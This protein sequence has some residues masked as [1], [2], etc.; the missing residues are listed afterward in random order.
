MKDVG[1]ADHGS[2]GNQAPPILDAL[3]VPKVYQ[4]SSP[5]VAFLP[6]PEQLGLWQFPGVINHSFC[7]K[8][9][10]DLVFLFFFNTLLLC[11]KALKTVLFWPV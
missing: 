6:T 3:S 2:T 8:E 10:A 11:N 5:A 7:H 9:E 4:L 1:T